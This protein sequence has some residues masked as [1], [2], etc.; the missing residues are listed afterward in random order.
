MSGHYR[1]QLN[2]SEENLKQARSAL[3]RLYTALR[4]TDKSVAQRVARP[5][6]HVSLKR[7]TMTSTRRKLTPVLFDMAREV[8]RLKGEDMAAAN[9]MAAHLRKLSSVLGLLEQDPE[10]F[11][12]SGRRRMTVKLLK[13]KR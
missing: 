12:Q 11:L 13:L 6:K 4:G 1:S 9:G 5:L 10:A 8:N 7:W 3:E 2:Y